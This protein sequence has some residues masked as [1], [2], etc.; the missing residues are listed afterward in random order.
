MIRLPMTRA[1]LLAVTAAVLLTSGKLPAIPDIEQG[2]VFR[3]VPPR[4]P[5]P[6]EPANLPPSPT[7]P[8]APQRYQTQIVFVPPAPAKDDP[9][10]VLLIAHVPE[11][12]QVWLMGRRMRQK[13]TMRQYLSPPLNPGKHY[14][15]QARVRWVEDGRWVEEQVKVHVQAGESHCLDVQSVAGKHGREAT[16]KASLAKLSPEDRELARAQ[17]FCA[18][19]EHNRLGSM[20]KPVKVMVSGKAVFVCCKGCV[21]K[22][23]GNPKRTLGKVKELKAGNAR[24]A[25]GNGKSAAR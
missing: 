4:A 6:P 22:A 1:G 23:K 7:T 21:E 19:Q 16:I 25:R 11:H 3:D 15:Y 14:T 12:A 18:V 2:R 24:P 5:L 10:R 8:P 17:R 9:R 20:G 13:G